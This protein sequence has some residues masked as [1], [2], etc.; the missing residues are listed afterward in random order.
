MKAVAL[1]F[2]IIV[3]VYKYSSDSS[4]ELYDEIT[5]KRQFYCLSYI[6]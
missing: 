2:R 5:K 1:M 4:N 3:Y 6:C